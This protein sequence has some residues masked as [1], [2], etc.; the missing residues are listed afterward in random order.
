MAYDICRICPAHHPKT[1]TAHANR[2]CPPNTPRACEPNMP[3]TRPPHMQTAHVPTWAPHMRTAHATRTRL[4]AA[5]PRLVHGPPSI[6]TSCNRFAPQLARSQPVR[7]VVPPT[8]TPLT[9]GENCSRLKVGKTRLRVKKSNLWCH[10]SE[11]NLKR[12]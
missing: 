8:G 5:C 3:P 12:I 11:T 4:S 6:G 7:H 2:T 10:D 1:H 9:G